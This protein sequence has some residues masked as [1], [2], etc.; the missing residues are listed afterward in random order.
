MHYFQLFIRLFI[1]LFR[2]LK[3]NPRLIKIIIGLLLGT[4]C[5]IIY[6]V[7]VDELGEYGIA[8]VFLISFVFVLLVLQLVK[9]GALPT[10]IIIGMVLGIA[11]GIVFRDQAASLKPIG[12]IF[13]RLISLI[14]VPLVFVSLFLGTASMG[15]LRK[16]GRIG[17]KTLLYY[18]TTTVIAI[19]I[20][21]VLVNVVQP[22]KGV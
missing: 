12:T 6:K 3:K 11:A 22:G 18:M 9:K 2:A 14:V 17:G 7:N 21:L 10:K 16:L 4:F 13:I 20:G 8:F 5:A 19:L 1:D 15:D